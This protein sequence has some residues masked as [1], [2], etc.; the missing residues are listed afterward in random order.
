MAIVTVS[1]SNTFNEWRVVTNQ[2]VTEVNKTESGTAALSVDTLTAN[3]VTANGDI[4]VNGGDLTTTSATFNVANSTAT[5]V[6]VGGAATT[7]NLG[8]AT[9]TTT[10]RNDAS[11]SGNTSITG[12]L[13]VTGNVT[14]SGEL[15][16]PSTFT[17]DPAVVGD[18]TG[19]VVIK[20]NLQVDGTTTTINS[21][22]LT[23]DDL[24][25]VLA[26]GAANAAAANGAGITIDGASATIT[27][28]S[29]GDKF[30][31]NKALDLQT[32]LNVPKNAWVTAGGSNWL[33]M[34]ASGTVYVQSDGAGTNIQ[35]N[36]NGTNVLTAAT[37][38]VVINDA[39]GD[40]DFRVESDTDTHAFFVD[41]GNNKV[42]FGMSGAPLN[43]GAL[44]PAF[45]VAIKEGIAFGN[46]AYTYGYI[47][48]NGTAGDLIIRA[49]GYPANIGST[50]KIEL[51]V[52]T[53]GGSLRSQAIFDSTTA[54]FNEG[55]EDIDFRVESDTNPH[56]FFVDA[57]NSRIG[58]N[59]S[60]PVAVFDVTSPSE[61]SPVLGT[62][63]TRVYEFSGTILENN[64]YQIF[65]V[66][67]GDIRINAL[68]RIRLMATNTAGI[69]RPN[70]S[71]MEVS[72]GKIDGNA[73]FYVKN[74]DS[75]DISLSLPVAS[76][77][78]V[79]FGAFTN[80]NGTAQNLGYTCVVELVS[81]DALGSFTFT[82]IAA[83]TAHTGDSSFR[84]YR[85][86]IADT[87]ILEA[88]TSNV[89]F[90]EGSAD[91][92]FRIESDTN[93]HAFFV[94]AGNSRVGINNS[95]P[96]NTLTMSVPIAS[97]LG[98]GS[99]G[100]IIS[101][102][103]GTGYN[104]QLVRLGASYNYSGAT[105][106]PTV[107]AAMLYNYGGRFFFVGDGA[108][109]SD[110]VF[111]TYGSNRLQIGS[112]TYALVVNE[113]GADYDF[114]VESDANANRLFVD[115]GADVV[116]M[117]TTT[118]TN[119]SKLVVDGTI[120]ETVSSAQ[121]LVASL[122]D[123][124]TEPNKIPLN[125]YLGGMAYQS[126]EAVSING[127][128]T[129]RGYLYLGN[130]QSVS[131]GVFGSINGMNGGNSATIIQMVSD[132]SETSG[133]FKFFTT[134]SSGVT[135][136][137]LQI[138]SAEVIVN[139]T[140]NDLDFRVESDGS[141][142]MLF[143]DA[144][145]NRINIGGS[146][147]TE[148]T[149]MVHGGTGSGYAETFRVR[150]GGD[151]ND[152]GV[153]CFFG[154]AAEGNSRGLYLTAGRGSSDRTLVSFQL[155]GSGGV[156]PGTSMGSS[157]WEMMR[158]HNSGGGTADLITVF[159]EDG[160]D[161]DFRVEGD[162]KTHLI[163][164]DAAG[165]WVGINA[166]T[167]YASSQLFV[168]GNITVDYNHTIAMRYNSS[169]NTNNY[170]KGMTGTDLS[171]SSAR[172]LHIF[173]YDADADPGI[174]FWSGRPGA[175][176]PELLATITN[177]GFYLKKAVVEKTTI[178]A[179]AP[180]STTNFDII[181]QAIQYYTSNATGNFTFNIRGNSGTSLNN[182]LSTGESVTIALLVTCGATAYYPNVIQVDGSTVTPKWQG[183]TAPTAGNASSI[184]IY[185]FTVIKT[186]NATFTV[187]ASQTKFA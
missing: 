95:S 5:T 151:A 159:N 155:N 167:N 102:I 141:T 135:A 14:L 128:G 3:T 88:T 10:I 160:Y 44:S 142:H 22:T 115:A 19:T 146:S 1:T 186:G 100:I 97:T 144:G 143:V 175:G 158:F 51:A 58:V 126:N 35:L 81:N 104:T 177:A 17:I 178:S 78:D 164:A 12:T 67:I 32:S 86:Y 185:S 38:E 13:G 25:I 165:D 176:S 112:D 156:V 33:L 111:T 8:A 157:R 107:G 59:N 169:G 183:G 89:V 103:S 140:S 9:G 124:G 11:V 116:F 180:S 120:S 7:L 52:G 36:P 23:V 171:T 40:V 54:T 70:A 163:F 148:T 48:Q 80:N 145:N 90:N 179:S 170:Y 150:A 83:G 76:G 130:T 99:D 71:T 134:N 30:S 182:M 50:R 154:Q 66:T 55:G 79:I 137:R 73:Y 2:L 72:V 149:L 138:N 39:S 147:T 93:T 131:A 118:N 84:T 110:F 108:S 129:T 127:L 49:N 65:K 117:G 75:G 28:L 26:S 101:N 133:Y 136:E 43:N 29:S 121:Y 152:T 41:A 6:N 187:I 24:N 162:T 21:T 53:T 94:D 132:G 174:N 123:I 18:D 173:N 45:N 181:T 74:Q 37:G 161:V 153:A 113:D 60:S 15:R 109:A 139:D 96:G 87:S 98:S 27:Y 184:D 46:D 114:R 119:S 68:L 105:G 122:A 57:G 91:V 56:A 31:I 20:G 125:A 34:G 85:K 69:G 106:A 77:N 62:S 61:G 92:D 63:R 166:S 4:A 47:G 82:D 42:I 172:G 16:G 168:N 64:N